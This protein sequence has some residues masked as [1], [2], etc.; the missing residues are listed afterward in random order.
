MKKVFVIRLALVFVILAVTFLVIWPLWDIYTRKHRVGTAATL[1]DIPWIDP[2][3][4]ELDVQ[5]PIHYA[6]KVDFRITGY[7]F[8]GT[9]NQQALQSFLDHKGDWLQEE[10]PDTEFPYESL[11]LSPQ[12]FPIT[13]ANV[14]YFRTVT[15]DRVGTTSVMIFYSD[16]D[17]RITVKVTRGHRPE[18]RENVV[19]ASVS[20]AL[21]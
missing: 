17:S 16:H 20:G 9:I 12:D 5:G 21:S 15:Q 13:N 2:V 1:N 18:D 3:F 7:L 8:S 14:S 10:P 4:Q 11:G 6:I 19:S